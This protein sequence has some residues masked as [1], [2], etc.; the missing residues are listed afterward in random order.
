[1]DK[2]NAFSLFTSYPSPKKERTIPVNS[3]IGTFHEV[4]SRC[5]PAHSLLLSAKSALKIFSYV[6]V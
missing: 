6:T 5:F 3:N 4:N 1:M 2:N